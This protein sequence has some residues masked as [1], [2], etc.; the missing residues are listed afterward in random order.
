[1]L[2]FCK[3][4]YLD[5]TNFNSISLN[6]KVVRASESRTNLRH[7]SSVD[8]RA[9]NCEKREININWIFHMG[10]LQTFCIC[11]R[12][13]FSRKTSIKINDGSLL[14]RSFVLNSNFNL[15]QI[16]KLAAELGNCIF[17]ARN[18]RS[19]W[20]E[21]NWNF[22]ILFRITEKDSGHFN[23]DKNFQQFELLNVDN[24]EKNKIEFLPVQWWLMN[25]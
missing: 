14:V 1:M 18:V 17:I 22:I 7:W 23:D 19:Y 10:E 3:R 20:H 8:C 24:Y 2:C 5:F 11:K 21:Y 13:C 15:S 25:Y 9:L 16:A 4:K 12:V 6:M